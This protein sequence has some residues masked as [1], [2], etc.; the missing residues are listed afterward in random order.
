MSTEKQKGWEE[1]F[2]A[3]FPILVTMT[4]GTTYKDVC[5]RNKVKQFISKMMEDEILETDVQVAPGIWQSKED[6]E[7]N[8][9]FDEARDNEL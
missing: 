1:K 2:E 9:A 5:D 7:A 8:M 6:Y 3:A 4:D